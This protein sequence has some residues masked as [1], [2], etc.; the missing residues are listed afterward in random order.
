MIL[1]SILLIISVFVSG[2]ILVVKDWRWCMAS[3]IVVQ[4]TG[5]I[6]ILQIWPIALASVKLISGLMSVALMSA[7]IASSGNKVEKESQPGEIVFKLMLAAFSLIVIAASTDNLISWLPI[8]YT[9]LF[10]GL[11][12]LFCGFFYVCIVSEISEIAVGLL[13]FL[14]GFDIIYSSLEGSALVTAIYATVILLISLVSSY[15]QGGFSLG[16]SN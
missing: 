10:V 14:V 2:F 6:L 9:N 5:F 1:N 12:F 13:I 3:L 16:G 4:L 15:L 8:S 7:T 11:A